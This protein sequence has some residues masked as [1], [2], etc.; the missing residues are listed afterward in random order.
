MLQRALPSFAIVGAAQSRQARAAWFCALFAALASLA[1]GCRAP[2]V[3]DEGAANQVRVDVQGDAANGP[4]AGEATPTAIGL[5][6][7]KT[8]TPRPRVQLLEPTVQPTFTPTET[9]TP[10]PEL[11]FVVRVDDGDTIAVVIGSTIETVRYL[12]ID[13]P[14]PNE[15][16]GNLA[17]DANRALVQNQLVTLLPDATLRD[18]FGRLPRYVFLQDGRF[19]NS[20]LV[21]QGWAR[22]IE[23][24][25]DG[26][27]LT[28]L[29][30]QQELA[31]QGGA[32]LWR[33]VRGPVTTQQ[34]TLRRG[35]GDLFPAAETLNP[36]QP[37]AIDAISPDGQWYRLAGSG[38]WI[39]NYYVTN[40][41]PIDALQF[42]TVPTPTP[43]PTVATETPT[44]APPTATPLPPPTLAPGM[45]K[46]LSVDKNDEVVV[47]RNDTATP[48]DLDGWKLLS[49]A[50]NEICFLHG[51]IGSGELLNIYTTRGPQGYSCFFEYPIWLD[52]EEDA[53]LLYAP[54][55]LVVSTFK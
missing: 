35:P 3:S 33:A 11:G 48:I 22:A 30:G 54:T 4:A 47:I 46:I 51:I 44:P 34:A 6:L 9:P 14:A 20:E 31:I 7:V 18:E 52:E 13:A 12:N 25:P 26:S 27:R 49:E 29:R 39:A 41:P 8:P 43:S 17:T 21:R 50:G 36:N 5:A 38:S 24:P 1:A 53:A 45:I 42:A 28:E 37:L 23:E 40:A 19:V 16:M 55:G 2:L 32:G 10:V 15:P